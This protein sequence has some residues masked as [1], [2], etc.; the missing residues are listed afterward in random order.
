M[1][2]AVVSKEAA[3]LG[4]PVPPPLTVDEAA[5][6]FAVRGLP[7]LRLASPKAPCALDTTR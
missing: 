7:A 1:P 4:F 3:V 5:R 2:P 6:V